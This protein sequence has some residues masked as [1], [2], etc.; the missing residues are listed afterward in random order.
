MIY[1]L[2]LDWLS[3]IKQFTS[4]LDLNISENIPLKKVIDFIEK[5]G[6]LSLTQKFS[7]ITITYIL[8]KRE[9]PFLYLKNI[10]LDLI[11]SSFKEVHATSLPNIEFSKKMDSTIKELQASQQLVKFGFNHNGKIPEKQIED[12][13]YLSD[14]SGKEYAFEVKSKQDNEYFIFA[15]ENYIKGKMY[16]N[17]YKKHISIIDT[18]IQEED[19]KKVLEFFDTKILVANPTNNIH[20]PNKKCFINENKTFCDSDDND[21]FINTIQNDKL[22]DIK[23]FSSDFKLS[24]ELNTT[25]DFEPQQISVTG[26]K[27]GFS[28]FFKK[29][30]YNKNVI[31]LEF[32]TYLNGKL[33]DI[34]DQ[35]LKPQKKPYRKNDKFGGFVY[36]HIPWNWEWKKKSISKSFEQL[37]SKLMN[38]LD[39]RFPIYFYL[40]KNEKQNILI[41][42]FTCYVDLKSTKL[43]NKKKRKRAKKLK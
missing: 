8:F 1:K 3:K 23:I 22:L 21:Y 13:F 38:N 40:Y 2:E 6:D 20:F 4:N 34:K 27:I 15:L 36:L 37:V 10:P 26:T 16:L 33:K 18:N 41:K 30:Q 42:T 25:E 17:N 35:Y 28:D 5:N 31:E 14:D 7:Q 32:E 39:I 11:K 43:K 12:D 19:F 9:H 29:K 24:M